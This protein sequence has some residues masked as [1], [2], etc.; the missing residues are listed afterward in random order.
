MALDV[1]VG[2]PSGR[3][4]SICVQHNLVGHKS[5]NRFDVFLWKSSAFHECWTSLQSIDAPAQISIR[6]FDQRVKNAIALKLYSFL[7]ANMKQSV[8]L[9]VEPNRW[10]TEFDASGGQGVYDLAD[11]VANDAKACRRGVRLNNTTESGLG[12][13]SHWVSLI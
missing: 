5:T 9:G 4:N 1:A 7:T 6:Q 10:K 8:L 3:A 11:V 13:N 2:D 12:V